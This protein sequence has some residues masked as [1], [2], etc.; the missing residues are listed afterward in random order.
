MNARQKFFEELRTAREAKGITLEEVSRATL[1][2]LKYLTAIEEGREDVLPTAYLRAFIRE[3]AGAIGLDPAAVIQQY[4]QPSPAPAGA[5]SA[6]PTAPVAARA[7]IA[8]E[9]H[10]AWWTNRVALLTAI[11]V[12][13]VCV[14]A[15]VLYLSRS[16]GPSPVREI[17]FSTAV[18]DNERRVFPGDTAKGAP[19][20]TPPAAGDSL[21]L[22]VASTDSVW[23]QLSIDGTPPNDY[24]F[25]PNV[26]RRWKAKDKF[27][28]SLGNAGGMI[29]KLNTTDIGALGKRGSIVRNYEFNRRSLVSPNAGRT[30]P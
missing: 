13:A 12:G 2:D 7:P 22:S 26:R 20:P 21:V 4:D 3:Y 29:F 6:T 18:S 15:V 11:S 16:V 28:I 19:I 1:I 30:T 5:G 27:T 8:T 14:I 24:L 23:M 25:A 17:P 9:P 10:R